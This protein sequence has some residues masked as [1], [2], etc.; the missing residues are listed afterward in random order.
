MSKAWTVVQIVLLA[1]V[2]IVLVALEVRDCRAYDRCQRVETFDCETSGSR[3]AVTS[4]DW[5]CLDAER[6]P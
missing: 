4:C 1:F 5:R 6:G 2:L 3:R